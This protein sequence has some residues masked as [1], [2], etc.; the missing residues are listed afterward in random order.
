MAVGVEILAEHSEVGDEKEVDEVDVEGSYADVL[1]STT[2]D[3]ILG[4][5]VLVVSE[6]HEYD[7]EHDVHGQCTGQI[8]PLELQVVPFQHIESAEEHQYH[9]QG[10]EPLGIEQPLEPVPIAVDDVAVK[11]EMEIL[12][13]LEQARRIEESRITR[14]MPH[15]IVEPFG[16]EACGIDPIRR[17][18]R[19]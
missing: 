5:T 15:G 13:D 9:N 14:L 12:H 6:K 11:E 18:A 16:H 10:E 1:Q 3:A 4:E 19:G 7:G 2:Y 17:E 8:G